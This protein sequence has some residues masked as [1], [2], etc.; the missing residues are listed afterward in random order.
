MK[1]KIVVAI[2]MIIILLTTLL[3]FLLL[4]PIIKIDTGSQLK[5]VSYNDDISKCETYTCYHES[6][7]YDKKRNISITNFNIKKYFIFYLFTLEYE[8]GNLC[9]TEWQ[10][11]EKYIE[12]FI[13]NAEII[14][15]SD[16]IDIKNLI[17][18]KTAVV[19]NTRYLDNDYN[20]FIEFKLDNKYDI[21]YV[22]YQDDLLILQ[23]GSP[24]E[25]TKF[26]AYK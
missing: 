20:T 17:E 16:N 8:K 12:N 6:V 3:I 18:G 1:K 14:Y 15:N 19:G 9:D 24:D 5:F 11:E 13:N 26:I 22:F 4:M 25:T 23:V 2:S 10:L 21:M 7:S